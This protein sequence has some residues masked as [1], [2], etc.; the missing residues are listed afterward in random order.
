MG[1][2][3]INPVILI[4]KGDKIK[5]VIDA[6]YLNSITDLT[7]Y[8]WPLEPLSTLLQKFKGK[9]FCTSDLSSAYNQVPLTEETQKLTT[10]VIGS[11]QY[12]FLN[13]FYGLCG[14]PNFFSRIMTIHFAPLIKRKKT[15]TYIDD[16]LMQAETKAELFDIIREYHAF[17]RSS[18]LK[19]DPEK[20]MFFL[21]KV[22]FLGHMVS[23]QRVQP[24]AK[25]VEKCKIS[26]HQPINRK[27]WASSDAWDSIAVISR[28][29]TLIQ[30]L[31]SISSAMTHPLCGQKNTNNCSMI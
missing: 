24:I 25:R 21:E 29:S 12:A 30:N 20:T 8:S 9:Y 15:I 10:F 27:S 31:S 4:P 19:S 2:Y 23:G 6:R 13:G 7:H 3:F 18:G 11:K 17:L 1:S 28:T 16:T 5:L 22:Q 26:S 14:L